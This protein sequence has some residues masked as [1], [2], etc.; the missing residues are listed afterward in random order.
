MHIG[1]RSTRLRTAPNNIVVIPNSTVRGRRR[2]P[3]REALDRTLVPLQTP[4][5]LRVF[6]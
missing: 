1:W 5:F 2:P 6:P 3:W 4:C